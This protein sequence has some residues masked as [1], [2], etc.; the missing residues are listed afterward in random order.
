MIARRT[1]LRAGALGL[2]AGLIPSMAFAAAPTSRRLIFII[3]RGAADGLETVIPAGDPQL[4]GLRGTLGV[5]DPL[6]L[7]GFF[8]LHPS[9]T[10]MHNLYGMGQALFAHSVATPYR[11]RSHFDA[12][13]VLETGGRVA[14]GL[15]SG[16]LNRLVALLPAGD[17][18]A[19][20]LA[21]SIPVALRGPAE[22]SS[23]AP[24]N[25]PEASADLT[26]R[27]AD[28]YAGDPQLHTLWEQAL[29]TRA[30]AG[31]VGDFAGRDAAA[32]GSLAAK[33]M[34]GPGGARIAMIETSGWDTHSG[35]RARLSNQLKGL[36]A[37]VAALK[38]GLAND[39]AST[40]VIVATEFGRTAAANGTGGTDHGTASAALL[41]GGAVNGGRVI[42]DW[43]GLS[44]AN[45]YEGR[46]LK[47]TMALDSLIAGAV[48]GHFALDPARTL[49]A[50][51]PDSPAICPVEGLIRA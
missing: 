37:M 45:L 36:D 32:A 49:G 1:L 4:S 27:V 9:L 7:D 10:G 50:L 51:F 13:N 39:W 20:A 28:L 3:Q 31:S 5:S 11:D 34:A 43:P 19:L 35:Q 23:Y 12:Q 30:M 24:S 29:A 26:A 18:R 44:A 47:P 8:A 15:K 41:L 6:K 22:V 48:A 38:A 16:W 14:Y 46:D 21:P 42:A 2:G 40:L 17:A 25:L 33:L